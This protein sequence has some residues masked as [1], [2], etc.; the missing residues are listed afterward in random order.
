VGAADLLRIPPYGGII[1]MEK[2]KLEFNLEDLKGFT[3]LIEDDCADLQ[4]A[5]LL[6][7]RKDYCK[8]SI[9]NSEDFKWIEMGEFR[10]VD[11][12]K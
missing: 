2:I 3:L 12:L 10:V 1:K 4:E 8:F 5:S 9:N 11:I 6:E 7:I